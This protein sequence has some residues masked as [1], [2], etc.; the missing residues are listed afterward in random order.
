MKD[1]ELLWRPSEGW[2]IGLDFGTAFSKAAATFNGGGGAT[3]LR[4]MFPLHI[5]TIAGAT[6]PLMAPSEMFLDRGHIHL[7]PRAFERFM[8]VGDDSRE[9]LQS[10]KMVLGAYDFEDVLDWRLPKAIDP[11]RG[12]TRGDLMVVYLAY[13]LELI[14]RAAPEEIGSL[15]DASSSVRLRYSRP[16]WIPSRAEAAYAAMERLF[17]F[18]A[19]VRLELGDELLA[20]EGL[21]FIRAREALG[22]AIA[23][24]DHFPGFDGAIYEASAVAACHFID[25][26]VPDHIFVADIGAGTTDFAGFIRRGSADK[27]DVVVETQR[28]I[29]VAGDMFDRALMNLFLKKTRRK[30]ENVLWRALLPHIRALKEELVTTGKT[31]FR[32]GRRVLKCKRA[33]FEEDMDYRTAANAIAEVQYNC[34]SQMAQAVKSERG[35]RIGIVFAGGG[36]HLR[37]TAAMLKRMRK[38]ARGVKLQVLP[39]APKWASDLSS[40][41]EFNAM[42]SQM[43]VAFGASMSMPN[44]VRDRAAKSR[45]AA[46]EW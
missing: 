11:D 7:G 9:M 1:D 22:K 40:Q 17:Q 8:A 3:R 26:T 46:V 42:F 2:A 18:A 20:P 14:E 37:S 41:S 44:Q 19:R 30:D 5:G 45:A 4:K 27:L 31:K 24:Q 29:T 16:G 25:P 21:S 34:I 10:F 13:L 39:T 12:F 15:F 28:T 38:V 32:F 33:E 43:C 23:S 6:H 36:S 35:K